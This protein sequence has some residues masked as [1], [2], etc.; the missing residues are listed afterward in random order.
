MSFTMTPFLYQTRTI[1]RI[2][3]SRASAIATRAL[4]A[5][6]RRRKGGEIPFDYEVGRPEE[7]ETPAAPASKGTITPAER[8]IFERI[9]A[10]IQARGLKPAVDNLEAP[11]PV[12]P[13]TASRSAMLI[14]QQ[15]AYDSGQAS[16]S[17]VTSPAL[18]S[19]AAHDRAQALLRFPPELRNAASKALNTIQYQATGVPPSYQLGL[20]AE[21]TAPVDGDWKTP[22][23]TFSRTIEV[24]EKRHAE[25]T[26]VEGLIEAAQT[27]FALWDVL[28]EE[29]FTMPVRLGIVK[30][31]EQTANAK[32]RPKTKKPAADRESTMEASNT[33][34]ASET[35]PA[36]EAGSKA[37][38]LYVHGPLYP[39]YLLL[40][41]RRLNA[42]FHSPSQLVF[43]LL[44]RIKEL[45]LES[46]VLGVST[47][48]FNELIDIYWTRRGNLSAV[49]EIL[50]EMRHC[51]LYFDSR[52]ASILDKIDAALNN[53]A[54]GS[55]RSGFGMALMM[56]PEYEKV[57][58]DRIRHWHRAVDL[59]VREKE[60]DLAFTE[61]P[62]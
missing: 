26:R 56:M 39:A 16:H 48:F 25:R 37:L 45:G 47:P 60:R 44:P 3:R 27:D 53:L 43:S 30:G 22:P 28:E 54:V 50:E 33:E 15:A 11:D 32:A 31:G 49:L 18:L 19:G 40:A 46:Y 2:P 12:S 1:L 41:L 6:P 17:T 29:V 36:P 42:A 7:A 38:S 55:S 51:G 14:M 13:S 20:P 57:Q 8:Q 61:A 58:R 62:V 23:S 24:E 21:E 5:T 4:H 35:S 9:F 10:D 34:D 52:T 59:S